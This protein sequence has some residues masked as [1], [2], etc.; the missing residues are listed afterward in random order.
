ML[1]RHG[2]NKKVDESLVISQVGL[3][4][5]GVGLKKLMLWRRGRKE[6]VGEGKNG[7]NCGRRRKRC[8]G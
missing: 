4:K 8:S 6:E 2:G 5:N 1:G 3:A 7:V